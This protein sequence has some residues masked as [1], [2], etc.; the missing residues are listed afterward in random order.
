MKKFSIL[1]LAMMM[2]FTLAACDSGGG[3]APSG[4][5]DTPS[6]NEQGSVD[7]DKDTSSSSQEEEQKEEDSKTLAFFRK[8]LA[9]N[10]TLEL[11]FYDKS[12]ENDTIGHT[13]LIVG[14]GQKRY[15]KSTYG[16]FIQESLVDG[17]FEYK[18][19]S[20]DKT[21]FKETFRKPKTG[22]S[23]YAAFS[24]EESDYLDMSDSVSTMEIK[25]K[26][27]RCETFLLQ[28][29]CVYCFDGD[30]LAYIVS[31]AGGVD[32]LIGV[33][34]VSTETDAALLEIPAD[35]KVS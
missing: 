20:D 10:Y 15:I 29:K 25:G 16:S 5:N 1:L 11:D 27:Y 12:Q 18:L 30:T 6:Q 17:E 34:S 14:S 33:K 4:D 19:Y 2:V 21:A 24:D 31:T 23:F 26:N 7:E 3:E 28:N 35:Y 8:Y 32:F 9:G 13:E 22:M